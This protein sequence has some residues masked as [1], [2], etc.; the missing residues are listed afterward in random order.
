MHAAGGCGEAQAVSGLSGVEAL[1]SAL[2]KFNSAHDPAVSRPVQ[3]WTAH[4]DATASAFLMFVSN[5]T[6]TGVCVCV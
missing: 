6:A 2:A 5:V 4:D 3:L 1:A